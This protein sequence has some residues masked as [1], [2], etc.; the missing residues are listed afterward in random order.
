VLG[1]KTLNVIKSCINDIKKDTGKDI[2]N[3]ILFINLEDPNLIAN[4][5]KGNNLGIFQMESP[6]C[7]SLI[8]MVNPKTFEDICAINA[9]NRPGPFEAFGNLYGK[10]KEIIQNGDLKEIEELKKEACP[11]PFMEKALESTYYCMIYQE[12]LMQML[13]D[14][15]DFNLGEADNLRRAIAWKPDNPKFHTVKKYFDK[16]AAGMK[17]KGYSEVDTQVF[18]DYCRKFSGYSFNKSHSVSYAVIAMQTL[19]LKVYYPGYFFSNHLNYEPHENYQEVIS[20]TMANNIEI[21]PPSITKSK[22]RFTTENGNKVRAGLGALKGFGDK[23]A[24]ELIALDVSKCENI[25][26]V[27]TKPFKKVNSKAFQC[28][29]DCG[30]FDEFGVDREKIEYLKNLY[31]EKKIATWFSRKRKPRQLETM[32][33]ILLDFPEGII[34]SAAEEVKDLEMPHL[35]FITKLIP[36]IKVKKDTERVREAKQDEVLGFSLGLAQKLNNLIREA[37]SYPELNLQSLTTRTSDDDL[38]YWFLL[39]RKVSKTKK[40]K[41]YLNLELTDKNTKLKAKCWNMIDVEKGKAYISQIKSDA[42][43]FTVVANEYLC[44]LPF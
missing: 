1:L 3:D 34:L 37:E 28:L 20:D 43:G 32:P 18:V 7:H 11:F 25:D 22:I 33:D 13:V 41:E 8:K 4:Y 14:A 9:I 44:E 27:F 23:A 24:E 2:T 40:G 10:R 5:A 35:A 30:A 21:L 39:D 12:Q 26:E 16:L 31:K 6:M 29:I 38:C 15:A 42:W 36:Y 19:Y 17:E